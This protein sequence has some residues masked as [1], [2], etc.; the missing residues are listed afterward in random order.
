[1]LLS[2]AVII[3]ICLSS[4][5]TA[6]VM[7]NKISKN[8]ESFYDNN[9][10]VTV[11]T[12]IARRE[13]QFA[14]ADIL[15]SILETDEKEKIAAIESASAA[16]ANMRAAFPVI[17]ERFKGD[18]ALVDQLESILQQAV[19]YRDQVFQLAEAGQM[20]QAFQVMKE[21]Y[22]PLLGQ[23]ADVL[24]QISVQADSNARLMVEKG[25]QIWIRYL[26][27]TIAVIGFSIFFAVVLGVYISNGIRRPVEE[28][29]S[30]AEKLAGGSL[31]V[32]INY[33]S[34]DELGVLSDSMRSLIYTIRGIIGDMT[35]CLE[36]LG[37]GNFTV[38]SAA[39]E[40]YVGD[41]QQLAVSMKQITEK[42]NSAMIQIN[43]TSE[44]V[45]SGSDQISYSAQMLAQGATEQAGAIEE[46]ASEISEIS[47]QVM[48]NAKNAKQGNELAKA[49][50]DKIEEGNRRVTE[51][52]IAMKEISDKS[53]QVSTIVKTIE[54]IAL[55]THILSLNATVEAVRAGE[56]GKGFKVVADEVRKLAAK[57]AE[58]SKSTA[59]LIEQSAQMVDK[60]TALAD[61]T[62]KTLVEVVEYAKQVSRAVGHISQ[63]SNE[64]ASSIAQITQGIEQ[65]SSV[66]QTNSAT[67][68]ENAA[69][70]EELSGQ[71]QM[72]K[73]LVAKFRLREAGG[74]EALEKDDEKRLME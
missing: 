2:Y 73:D 30:E 20:E 45:S 40:L 24:T 35:Y 10:M 19:V 61:E 43:Q 28:I 71:A 22:N 39:G 1:M 33:R 69:A 51:M 9:Y 56:M 29:K 42:L 58:A 63:A 60:G 72:L 23:M 47:S 14:R 59:V 62:A 32:S 12:W 55:Q 66:V 46:L 25:E 4:S 48:E 68:E 34:E 16:L 49:A 3:A 36:G 54:D 13:M 70:G 50:G 6:L 67:A 37:N 64:Q 11:N 7:M 57:S 21:D 74:N 41:F 18:M 53:A 8:L 65:I 52:I 15:R 27:I 38:N 5:I 17:R 31:N 26:L 44:Q